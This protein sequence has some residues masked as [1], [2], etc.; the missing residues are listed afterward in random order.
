[1]GARPL[2]APCL[3]PCLQGIKSVKIHNIEISWSGLYPSIVQPSGCTVRHVVM[4]GCLLKSRTL[5]GREVPGTS[6]ND[7][8]HIMAFENWLTHLVH[9][10]ISPH[11]LIILR[12]MGIRNLWKKIRPKPFACAWRLKPFAWCGYLSY[13]CHLIWAIEWFINHHRYLDQLT[14]HPSQANRGL[15]KTLY[16]TTQ[17]SRRM[18]VGK[19]RRIATSCRLVKICNRPSVGNSSFI[20]RPS[21]GISIYVY[22]RTVRQ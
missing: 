12:N 9:Q 4:H 20:K 5:L 17:K 7:Y 18:C 14:P 11:G 2:S 8:M 22:H 1:M 10:D 19:S 6:V 16:T 3:R 21:V 15:L 13:K